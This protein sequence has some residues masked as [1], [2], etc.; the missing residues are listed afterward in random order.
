MKPTIVNQISDAVG[1]PRI[2]SIGIGPNVSSVASRGS[3][4]KVLTKPDSRLLL[5]EVGHIGS[6]DQYRRATQSKAIT[7]NAQ[8]RPAASPDRPPRH[9]WASELLAN[10]K[11]E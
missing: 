3:E 1:G 2:N 9:L 10:R 5:H 11:A 6:T 8:P 7:G 4:V